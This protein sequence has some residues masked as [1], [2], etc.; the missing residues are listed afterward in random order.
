MSAS[1]HRPHRIRPGCR[2]FA[3]GVLTLAAVLPAS[4]QQA[5]TLRIGVLYVTEGALASL[6]QDAARGIDMAVAE[7]NGSVA[8]KKLVIVREGTNATPDLA[9]QKA[10]KLVEQDQVDLV[11]GPLS[12]GEGLAIKEYA[13]TVP[14][15][16][17]INGTG[18][19]QDTTLRNPAPNFFSFRVDG[20][21]LVAGLGS[22]AYEVK[23]YRNV[24]VVAEDYSF[25]YAQ[26]AGFITEFCARGGRIAQRLWVP[27]GTKDYASVIARIP[28]QA[29]AVFTVLGGADAVNFLNQYVQS[30]GQ[31]PLIG[32]S[33]TVDSAVLSSKGPFQRHVVG[34]P[35]AS[36]TADDHDAP[37]WLAFVKAYRARFPDGLPVPSSMAHGYYVSMKAALLG[38]QQAGGDVSGDQGRFKAALAQLRFKTPTGDIRLDQNRQ[39][40]ADIF[41]TEVARRPDGSLYNKVVKVVSQVNASLGTPREAFVAQGPVSRTNPPCGPGA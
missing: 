11:V 5:D 20:V 40:I 23:N 18:A 27:L 29:D 6:G 16:T 17:F 13:R 2:P 7:F 30:G 10:R 31:A 8:G 21:Q 28:P 34:I 35:S 32:G 22:Y 25:P 4:G 14:R 24:A 37:E 36:S 12:G 9:V 1:F 3:V 15:K 39:A 41:V 38:L 19:A 26:V 33:I